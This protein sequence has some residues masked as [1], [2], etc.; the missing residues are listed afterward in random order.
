MFFT[1]PVAAFASVG[2]TLR[3]GGALSFACWQ[4]VSGN[5][6]MLI[7]GAVAEVT[8]SLPPMPGP[9]GWL[10]GPT[11]TWDLPLRQRYFRDG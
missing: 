2:R 8:G 1:D 4:G 11:S 7:R 3:P 5:K 10:S 6:W 9:D